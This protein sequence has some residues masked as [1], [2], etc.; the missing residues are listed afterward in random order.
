MIIGAVVLVV[1]CCAGAVLVA[2][3]GALDSASDRSGLADCRVPAGDP[4]LLAVLETDQ[5]DNGELIVQVGVDLGVPPRAW[6]IA[7][8]T[9]MQESG[10]RNLAGGD[11]DSLGLFQQRPSQGWGTPEQILDP[12]YASTVF[13][14][15]LLQ[16]EGWQDLPLAEAAQ[17]VQRSAFPDAYGRHEPLAL[18]VVSSVATGVAGAAGLEAGLRCAEIGEV[19]AA[20]WFRPVPGSVTSGFRTAARPTHYGIDTADERGTVVRAAADGT[21]VVSTCDA[22]LG[23]QPYSCDVDGSPQVSGC[24]WYVDLLHAGGVVTRYCHLLSRPDVTVGEQVVAGQQLG[25][26][27]TSGSSSGPH[28]HFE[29]ELRTIIG[30]DADGVTLERRQVDPVPFLAERGIAFACAGTPASC[31]PAYG[32]RVRIETRPG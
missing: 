22:T 24:G 10:L 3:F 7:V 17:A 18:A 31:E 14:E 20:G 8:A 29:V 4:A 5:L 30:R 21:V 28:L 15:R 11:R 13:Y 16:V 12:V 19:T 23:G 26:V 2:I 1:C 32:D 27:G 25:L 6:V 9:A